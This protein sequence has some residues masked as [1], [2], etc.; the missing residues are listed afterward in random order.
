MADGSFFFQKQLQTRVGASASSS[1]STLLRTSRYGGEAYES[2]DVF[3]ISLPELFLLF[4]HARCADELYK[5]WLQA[6]VVI[7]CKLRRGTNAGDAGH[8]Q[9]QRWRG[10]CRR[11]ASSPRATSRWRCHVEAML[12][13]VA[14]VEKATLYGDC[15]CCSSCC[16]SRRQLRCMSIAVATCCP[17]CSCSF[18]LSVAAANTA[19]RGVW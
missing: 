18:M 17:M 8:W 16:S 6:E 5:E 13:D 12:K 14:A 15:C 2:R 4:L 3:I 9:R 1:S 7:G 19:S 10:E 11:V